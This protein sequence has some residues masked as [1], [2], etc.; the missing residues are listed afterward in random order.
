MFSPIWPVTPLGVGGCR[1]IPCGKRRRIPPHRPRRFAGSRKSPTRTLDFIQATG[2]TGFRLWHITHRRH[3]MSGLGLKA[4]KVA[5]GRSATDGGQPPRVLDSGKDCPGSSSS[6]ADY[7]CPMCAFLPRIRVGSSGMCRMVVPGSSDGAIFD[8]QVYERGGMVGKQIVVARS[9]QVSRFAFA[10][11][12]REQ[13]YGRRRRV[14]LDADG[15]PCTRA[16]LLADGSVLLRS[17]MTGQGYFTPDGRWVANKDLEGI[18][19][20]GSPAAVVA[21]TLD[22]AQSLRG[23]LDAREVLDMHIANTYVLTA[24]E[25]EPALLA[26][27]HAGELFGFDISFRDDFRVQSAVLLA[28]DS[29][30]FV[31]VGY[32]TEVVWDDL[33]E[34][35]DS[36]PMDSDADDGIDELDFDF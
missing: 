17:G 19:V 5:C 32:P 13:I 15:A 6:A 3:P 11:L 8:R 29:G 36:A 22:A 20:D 35:P 25:V 31:L 16:S 10:P 34:S 23:P 26:D 14:A 18:G 30:V 12:R 4:R 2:N 9:G 33:Q 28:N 7:R 21:S 27:L 24:D 1:A